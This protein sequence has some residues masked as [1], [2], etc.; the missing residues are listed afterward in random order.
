[1][2]RT[3][4]AAAAA[5]LLLAG[6]AASSAADMAVRAPIVAP[7]VVW[8]W[9]GFYFG[10]H[11]GA[12]WGTSEAS[13]T[14]ASITPPIGGLGAVAF[15]LP[16]AQTSSSG[17]L[18]GVQGGYNWQTGWAVFGIQG[19][20]AGADIKGTSPCLV[21][22]GCNVKT[23]WLASVTGRIGAVVLDRGLVYAKGGVAWADTTHSV[24]SPNF[25]LGTGVPDTITSKDV[26]HV[27]WTVGLG[28]EWMITPNWTAFIEYNYYR[29]DTKNERFALNLGAGLPVQIAINADLRDSLSVAKVGVNY[30]FN[31][32]KNPVVA[33]Y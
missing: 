27:G 24:R 33:R 12:G 25:N 21:V 11:V 5:A 20:I 4:T 30:K 3:I 17:F 14:G 22:L 2:K 9:T 1:M 7:P 16:F 18:G 23:D 15:N 10:A 31:W 28:T 6:T 29:F 8:S 32:G 26:T 19:D 13:L